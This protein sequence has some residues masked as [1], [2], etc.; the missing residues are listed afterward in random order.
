MFNNVT[1]EDANEIHSI[2]MDYVDGLWK[3][4]NDHI[5]SSGCQCSPTKVEYVKP[6]YRD[7]Y[8]EI[9]NHHRMLRCGISRDGD[10]CRLQASDRCPQEANNR[11]NYKNVCPLLQQENS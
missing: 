1:L 10:F 4:N 11:A 5:P 6:I 8:G 3:E 2:P 9:Y 7:F